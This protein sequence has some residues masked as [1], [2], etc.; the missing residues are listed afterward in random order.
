MDNNNQSNKNLLLFGALSVIIILGFNYFRGP[1]TAVPPTPAVT[2]TATVSPQQQPTQTVV[3]RDRKDVVAE[4]QRVALHTPELSGSINLKGARFD[5]LTL[6]NYRETADP[7]S[8]QVVLLSPAGSAAPHN[9]YYAEFSWLADN[10]VAVPTDETEWKADGKDLTP[11]HPLKLT[12]N[13]GKGLTFERDIAVDDHFMFT[14]TDRVTNAGGE[15]V[16]LYPFGLVARQGDPVSQASRV[17]FEGPLGV[18]NGTLE[19]SSYKKLIDSG[20]RT[21][22]SD[23]GGWVGIS[24]KYWLVAMAPVGQEKLTADFQYDGKGVTDPYQGHFQ[25]DFRGSPVTVAAGATAQHSVHF[26]AGVKKIRLLDAY[27]D[28]YDIPHLDRAI[29][30]G[31][32]Y[33]LTKPFLYMLS[34][35]GGQLGG[36]GGAILVFTVMLKLMTLPLSLKSN[37]SMARMKA[38]Q[39]EIKRL[40][41]RYADDK[42]KLNQEMMEMFK[43][44]KV[45]PMSGCVPTLIQIPIFFALYKVLYVGI[46]M[47]QAPFYGWIRDMSLP[48][49][50]SWYNVFGL[51]HWALPQ[52]I[53]VNLGLFSVY[54]PPALHIGA[55]PMLMGCSMFLQQRLSPQAMDKQQAQMFRFMPILFTYMLS[56]MPAGLVVYWT[57]SNLLSI[58]Q[59]WLIMRR[60]ANK[61]VIKGK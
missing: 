6:S 46:E 43:R 27:A 35:L 53:M 17:L 1:S 9:A 58:G 50:T 14:L 34:F 5:D 57:W 18:L 20:K 16:T 21:L 4:T 15:P 44:E 54:V 23:N 47:R 8:P 59:Q 60:D 52:Q 55:W 45:S 13:N 40:Q 42:V 12:W 32:F 56:N 19:E 51:A 29:D 48:D 7:A 36:I 2:T 61:G 39:P 3:T 22:D 25:S 11:Q 33:F 26:M 31:W 41:E 30:F 28:K 37:H 38:L 49:P 10:G 24:S